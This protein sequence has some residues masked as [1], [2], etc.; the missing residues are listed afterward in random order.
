MAVTA[1]QVAVTDAAQVALNTA[2]DVRRVRLVVKNMTA[3]IAW[4]GPA[5]VTNADGYELLED[6]SIVVELAP[7]DVL[8]AISTAGGTTLSVLRS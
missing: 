6:E 4:L 5:A 7:G 1:A 2:G 3:E 8:Y